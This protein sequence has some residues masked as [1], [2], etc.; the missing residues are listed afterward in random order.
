MV[1]Y[2]QYLVPHQQPCSLSVAGQGSEGTLSD[3]RNGG[4]GR[5]LDT[6]WALMFYQASSH[7]EMRGRRT[8]NWKNEIERRSILYSPFSLV[9]SSLLQV[10][11]SCIRNRW[12][13][14]RFLP[15][16]L[17]GIYS[18][19]N[20]ATLFCY[21]AKHSSKQEIPSSLGWLQQRQKSDLVSL[22]RSETSAE[23]SSW[24]SDHLT[25]ILR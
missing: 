7:G 13:K 1:G 9:L 22:C 18:Q 8:S 12:N 4:T 10:Q 21:A 17:N 23:T 20:R 2:L 6:H 19:K 15:S 11:D 16:C 25:G 5:I 3:C 24:T 14:S